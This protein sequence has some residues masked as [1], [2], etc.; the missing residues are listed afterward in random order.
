MKTQEELAQ[1]ITSDMESMGYKLIPDFTKVGE[2]LD[3]QD[4]NSE[5]KRGYY[6]NLTK[7]ALEIEFENLIKEFNTQN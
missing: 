1:Y 3:T 6:Q 5:K 7:R 4:W 2:L